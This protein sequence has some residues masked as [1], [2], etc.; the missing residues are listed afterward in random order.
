MNKEQVQ[1]K[2]I[3]W[4]IFFT[5]SLPGFNHI[6]K[7]TLTLHL[8]GSHWDRFIVRCLPERQWGFEGKKKSDPRLF[9][10]DYTLFQKMQTILCFQGK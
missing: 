8:T 5:D 10:V 3:S 2:A 7:N 6:Q 4:G 9:C 1:L